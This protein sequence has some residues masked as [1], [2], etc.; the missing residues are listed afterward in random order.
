[1]KK[2]AR[3]KRKEKDEKKKQRKGRMVEV[4]RIVEEWEI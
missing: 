2:E 3:K 1:M 4:K